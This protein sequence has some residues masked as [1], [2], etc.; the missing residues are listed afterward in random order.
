[1]SLSS[2]LRAD[3]KE[4]VR[5]GDSLR[6]S[7]IRLAL[8]ALHNREIEKRG[9]L[10]EDE[11]LGVLS[12]EAKKRRESAQAYRAGGRESLAEQEEQELKII[13]KY[14][15][16]RLSGAELEELVQTVAAE[17]GTTDLSDLGRL[18]GAVMAKVKGRADGADVRR[19]AEGILK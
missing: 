1:M 14:L 2:L 17:I 3:L 11:G 15:P 6:V 7:V 12:T 8:A 10:T 19:A 18:M 4:A 9:D 16:E 13:E 5:S